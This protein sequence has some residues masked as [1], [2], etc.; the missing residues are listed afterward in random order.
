[1]TDSPESSL[2]IGNLDLGRGI[3]LAP[4]AGVADSPVRRLARRMGADMVCSEMV[5]AKGLSMVKRKTARA[6]LLSYV[7]H[8]REEKPFCA[9]LFGHEPAT[10][11]K[12][13]QM[14]IEAGADLVDINAGCPVKK[15]VSSGSGAALLRNPELFGR[16]VQAA[17]AAG[18]FPLTVKMRLG[19]DDENRNFL[20]LANI[21]VEAGADA[22]TLHGRTRAQMFGGRADWD[23]VAELTRT[24]KVP[25]IGNG[26]VTCGRDAQRMFAQTGCAG[27]MIGRAATGRPWI[28]REVRAVLEGKK[29][30]PDPTP[31]EI[32][33]VF[34]EHFRLLVE[35]KGAER[36]LKEIRKHL[37]AYT[38]GLHGAAILRRS[39]YNTRDPEQVLEAAE[40]FFQEADQRRVGGRS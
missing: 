40:R 7:A 36:A 1:M 38:R 28:F 12:A 11:T 13:A 10:F 20:E 27:V 9:Q 2:K 6:R 24:L 26:D 14:V 33:A 3:V 25:V 37:L 23:A 15:V 5:A 4:M 32:H 16:I 17:R 34:A 18:T 35:H 21:A 8:H 31:L 22:I 30:P 19:W 29:P 39:V